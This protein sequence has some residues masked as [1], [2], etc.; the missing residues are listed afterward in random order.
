MSWNQEA[1]SISRTGEYYAIPLCDPTVSLPRK[2]ALMGY[3]IVKA[4][5]ASGG[6]V[7]LTCI[8][9]AVRDVGVVCGGSVCVGM[10]KLVFLHVLVWYEFGIVEV[11][12]VV[13][14]FGSGGCMP[15]Y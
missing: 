5:P 12:V 8:Q 3:C 11:R 9:D 13:H 6:I 14:E 10:P 1:M 7:V 2:V 15:Y 4:A